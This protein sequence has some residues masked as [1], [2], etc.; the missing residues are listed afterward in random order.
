MSCEQALESPAPDS[1]PIQKKLIVVAAALIDQDG[2][3]LCTQRPKGKWLEGQWEFP[4]GKVEE[5]EV[6]EFALMRELREE[7]AIET[8]PTCF[9]PLSFISHIYEDK[10]T[11]VLMPL[12]ACRVWKGTPR[13]AEG[14]NM[15]W[16]K[17]NDMH[18]MD[19]VEAD[20]PLFSVLRDYIG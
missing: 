8:R 15:K 6:P 19:F 18:K 2:A 20:I 9:T 7:L 17:P 3:V 14:Q 10:N 13:G 16:V 4:G 5:G 1:P 11:H 12:Y